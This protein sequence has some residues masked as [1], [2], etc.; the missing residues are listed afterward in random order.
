[1]SVSQ[2]VLEGAM[3]NNGITSDQVMKEMNCTRSSVY[4]AVHTLKKRGHKIKIGK[5]GKYRLSGSIFAP[6]NI[7]G[8][9]HL[10]KK[11]ADAYLEYIRRS[12]FNTM[13]ARAII[14][15]NKEVERQKKRIVVEDNLVTDI[16]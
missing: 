14:E 7:Q 16:N 10:D 3:S 11:S 4:S 8:K 5:D 1:M 12:K 6:R 13:A 2:K 15:A 9:V